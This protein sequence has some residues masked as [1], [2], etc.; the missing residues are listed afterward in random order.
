[1]LKWFTTLP[2]C[3]TH[4]S[5]MIA[6]IPISQRHW[7]WLWISMLL[8]RSWAR[9]WLCF[10]FMMKLCRN[11]NR[12]FYIYILWDTLCQSLIKKR[13]FF[14]WKIWFCIV[15]KSFS[16]FVLILNMFWIFIIN[17]GVVWLEHAHSFSN[18]MLF[19]TSQPSWLCWLL[20]RINW[21]SSS[22]WIC[23]FVQKLFEWDWCLSISLGWRVILILIIVVIS[24]VWSIILIF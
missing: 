18:W 4:I 5:T 2:Y 10:Q 24:I 7:W 19:I 1:M 9:P 8:H 11:T 3:V 20:E 17:F 15:T 14:Y 23:A 6:S 12:L 22:S 16:L 21:N 13:H